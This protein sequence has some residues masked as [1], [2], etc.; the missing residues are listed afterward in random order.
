V[1]LPLS[2]TDNAPTP[3]PDST[4]G[5]KI[6]KPGYNASRTAG[7]NYI[8]NSSWPSLPVIYESTVTNTLGSTPTM[9]FTHNLGFPAFA[10]FW[11]Y[12][13]NS[14]GFGTVGM[15]FVPDISNNSVTITKSRLT[16]NQQAFLSTA[17]KIDVKVYRLDLSKDIDYILA[18]GDT[19]KQPYDSNFGIKVVKQGKSITSTDL[20]DYILHSRAQ[21]PLILAVKTEKTASAANVGV[22]GT[23]GAVQYTSH[24]SNPVWVYGFVK[25]SASTYIYAPFYSQSYPRVFTDGFT[26]YLQWFNYALG[27]GGATLVITRDPMFAPTSSAVVY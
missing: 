17:T 27:V 8:F 6:S 10:L 18:P 24:Q 9:T 11:A 14:S 3:A 21:S 20:R 2:M 22:G 5:F 12:G 25:L 1:S 23:D 4:V 19:F 13:P 7:S 15:R 26:S 16:I